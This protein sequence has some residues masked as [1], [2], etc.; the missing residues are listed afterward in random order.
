M[1]MRLTKPAKLKSR[2]NRLCPTSPIIP[3]FLVKRLNLTTESLPAGHGPTL[4]HVTGISRETSTKAGSRLAWQD[5]SKVTAG[6]FFTPL[7]LF[8]QY[9]YSNEVY[10]DHSTSF[11][12]TILLI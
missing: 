8:Q 10:S 3:F 4:A 7:R 12:N 2:N 9:F 11:P 5:R 6:D 1:H